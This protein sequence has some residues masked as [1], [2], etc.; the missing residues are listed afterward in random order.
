MVFTE[1]GQ[2]KIIYYSRTLPWGRYSLE[3]Q[4]R[5]VSTT[6]KLEWFWKPWN[7]NTATWYSDKLN[8]KWSHEFKNINI[9]QCVTHNFWLKYLVFYLHFNTGTLLYMWLI[10]CMNRLFHLLVFH[11][12]HFWMCLLRSIV[13]NMPQTHE[14]F[15]ILLQ[16]CFVISLCKI[17]IYFFLA[18]NTEKKWQLS[19]I[20]EW[21]VAL[22]GGWWWW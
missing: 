5:M 21:H 18:S 10:N 9:L 22:T 11:G 14:D 20:R 1:T 8:L 17:Y 7:M 13:R 12:R 2:G 4:W 16:L 6:F 19:H 3:D 15:K